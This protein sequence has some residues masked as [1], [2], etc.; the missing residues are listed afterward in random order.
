MNTAKA[1][2]A[3]LR[4]MHAKIDCIDGNLVEQDIADWQEAAI[5][6][7]FTKQG[8]DDL[9]PVVVENQEAIIDE[10]ETA[11][12]SAGRGGRGKAR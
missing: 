9:R 1:T 11:L 4:A 12:Q 7:Q 10:S 6:R 3:L 2:A 8:R 5:V